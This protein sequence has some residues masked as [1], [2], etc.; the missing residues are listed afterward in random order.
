[1]LSPVAR[2]HLAAIVGDFT[3]TARRALRLA[4][5]AEPPWLGELAVFADQLKAP[6]R[7]SVTRARNL[8]TARKRRQRA[9]EAAERD[10][11]RSTGVA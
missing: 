2:V 3:R 6:E 8:A 4:G 7:D 9:R 10:R 1:M 5:R 11:H